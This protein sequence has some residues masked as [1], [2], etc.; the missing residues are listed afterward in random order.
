MC[1]WGENVK[2]PTSDIH[3]SSQEPSTRKKSSVF[4]VYLRGVFFSHNRWAK[5]GALIREAVGETYEVAVDHTFF[6]ELV[7]CEVTNALGSTNISRNVDVYCESL[8]AFTVPLCPKDLLNVLQ[9]DVTCLCAVTCV[10]LG[11]VWD[12]NLSHYRWIWA[13]MPSLTAPGWEI[14]LS[15]LCGW[16]VATAW[17]AHSILT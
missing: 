12:P 9:I 5:G 17:Y 15:P 6:S 2:I 8:R 13:R 7:S 11:L 4:D 10:Q 14:P 16:N 3:R 1:K